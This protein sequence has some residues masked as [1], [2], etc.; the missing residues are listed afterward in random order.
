MFALCSYIT[1]G[2]KRL[3][4]VNEVKIES[5]IHK[6]MATAVISVPV[7]AVL[8]Q[9]EARTYIE[10]AKAINVWDRRRYNNIRNEWRKAHR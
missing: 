2:G 4:G 6:L 10:T 9:K 8:K 5:S 3:D 7:T 1:I